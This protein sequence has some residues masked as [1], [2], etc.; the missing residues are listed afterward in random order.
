[1]KKTL[2]LLS[3]LLVFAGVKAQ[4]SP[5]IKKETEKPELIKPGIADSLK[6]INTNTSLKIKKWSAAD[7][8]KEIK[9]T[10]IIKQTN[11]AIKVDYIKKTNTLPMKENNAPSKPVVKY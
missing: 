3:S 7:S 11:K 9:T 1:M 2:A 6:E 10:S 8:L 4:T 5:T